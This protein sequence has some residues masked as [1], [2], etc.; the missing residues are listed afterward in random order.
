M[1]DAQW[2]LL[3]LDS[4]FS[5]SMIERCSHHFVVTLLLRQEVVTSSH[6]VSLHFLPFSRVWAAW[7]M[8]C[9]IE[10]ETDTSRNCECTATP[11]IEVEKIANKILKVNKVDVWRRVAS[12]SCFLWYTEKHGCMLHLASRL[13]S[14]FHFSGNLMP[15]WI[16]V[17]V[18]SSKKE[19]KKTVSLGNGS[20]KLGDA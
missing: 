20:C 10:S 7:H 12:N 2:T 13:V 3:P 5:Y 18:H 9:S 11:V 4:S 19:K 6:F 8:K 17:T 15:P 14:M 16:L 1:N